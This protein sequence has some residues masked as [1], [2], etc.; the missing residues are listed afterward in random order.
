MLFMQSLIE[1]VSNIWQFIRDLAIYEKLESAHVGTEDDLRKT[2]FGET[3]YAEVAIASLDGKDVG[4][5]LYFFNYST[6]LAKVGC[7][8]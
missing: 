7:H 2:L 5:A 3:R 4:M 1:D 6:F 8:P